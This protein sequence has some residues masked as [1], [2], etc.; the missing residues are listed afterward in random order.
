MSMPPITAAGLL[1]P[2]YMISDVF[3]LS[4]YRRDYNKQVLEIDIIGMAI[5]I[6]FDGLTA[7]V[8]ID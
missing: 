2:V 8:V 4:A 7:H 1:L 6:A 5:S 3:A